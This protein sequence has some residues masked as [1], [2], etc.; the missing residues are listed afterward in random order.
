ML[1]LYDGEENVRNSQE[2]LI[3]LAQHIYIN[4]RE[5]GETSEERAIPAMKLALGVFELLFGNDYGFYHSTVAT[6]HHRIA[7]SYLKRGD[8]ERALYH[9]EQFAEHFIAFE[10]RTGGFYTSPLADLVEI[11]T[12]VSKTTERNFVEVALEMLGYSSLDPIRDDPR[13]TAIVGR[14]R[15]AA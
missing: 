6:T 4:C 15:N 8:V 13:F 12:M 11:H 2:N 3:K 1:G 7:C 10:T 5:I 14:L 9:L